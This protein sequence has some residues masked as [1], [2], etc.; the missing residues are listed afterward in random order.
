M[1]L[2]HWQLLCFHKPFLQQEAEVRANFLWATISEGQHRQDPDLLKDTQPGDAKRGPT[3][4]AP[5]CQ[6]DAII[7]LSFIF[8]DHVLGRG[9][10][11]GKG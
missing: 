11:A 2:G 5:R 9:T 6:V 10:Q 3:G 7:L 4:Q 8:T 1:V